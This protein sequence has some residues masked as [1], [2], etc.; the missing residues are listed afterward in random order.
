MLEETYNEMLRNFSDT[1]E[2]TSEDINKSA[3]DKYMTSCK[4]KVV[5]VDKLKDNLIKNMS[6]TEAPKSCDA[7]YMTSQKELFMIEFKNGVIDAKKNY[8]INGKI[9]QS[10]LL[11]LEKFSIQTDFTR[12]NMNFILVYNENVRHGEAEYENTGVRRVSGPIFKRASIREIRFG[13]H[14][15]RKLYFKD[16]FTYTKI[17]FESEFVSKYCV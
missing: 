13:L 8:E 15:F 5:N 6:L 7:L 14:R 12:D 1:L 16:V 9:F 10:L 11:L 17:E 2:K 3:T 4:L